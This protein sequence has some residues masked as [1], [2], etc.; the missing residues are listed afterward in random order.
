[1]GNLVFVAAH[2]AR[3]GRAVDAVGAGQAGRA[4]FVEIVDGEHAAGPALGIET[5]CG[6]F[7]M[8]GAG[9][10]GEDDP[11]GK[12]GGNENNGKIFYQTEPPGYVF[13]SP[14]CGGFAADCAP[15]VLILQSAG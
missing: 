1:M 2:I 14:P 8:C 5:A 15:D 13:G 6:V 11:A 3:A 9:R 10:A 7:V 12:D 4:V